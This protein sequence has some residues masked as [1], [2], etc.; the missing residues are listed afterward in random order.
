MKGPAF[1]LQKGL[2]LDLYTGNRSGPEKK[3]A[4]TKAAAQV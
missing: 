2:C 3:K 4:A 1:G